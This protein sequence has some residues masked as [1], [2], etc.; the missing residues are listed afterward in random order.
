MIGATPK[1]NQD[2]ENLEIEAGE[3]RC[4]ETSDIKTKKYVEHRE[5]LHTSISKIHMMHFD[6]VLEL[7]ICKNIL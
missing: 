7:G 1:E 3:A 2:V 5:Q 6:A 4:S